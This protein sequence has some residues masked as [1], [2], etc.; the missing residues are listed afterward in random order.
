MKAAVCLLL[1]ALAASGWANVSVAAPS[2]GGPAE[3]VPTQDAAMAL[4]Q[5]GKHKDALE[6][7]EQIIAAHPRDPA[8]ALF[9]ASTLAL[10]LDKWQ[11][12]KPYVR[13]LVKLRPGSMQAWELLVQVDQASGDTTGQQDAMDRMYSAWRSAL[14]PATRERVAF[15][16]DRIFG[17]K[18]TVVAEQTL[19]PGGDEI[20]RWIFAPMDQLAHP[21]HYLIVR[22]DEATN[23]RWRESGTVSYGTVVYHLDAVQVL[24]SGQTRSE[25]YEFYLSEPDYDRVRKKVAAILAGEAQPLSGDADPFWTEGP[26]Q[27]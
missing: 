10:E 25:P 19:D 6:A 4:L 11:E 14:D 27:P 13:S 16:R 24:G 22:S 26:A 20:V 9:E 2:A 7:F 12:A 18:R 3:S 8:V 21:A 5:A 23:E 1:A 15:T 17:P